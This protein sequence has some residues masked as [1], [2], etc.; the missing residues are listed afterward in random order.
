MAFVL[1]PILTFLRLGRLSRELEALSERVEQ[2]EARS[3]AA[4]AAE[5]TAGANAAA[6]AGFVS[7]VPDAPVASASA[8]APGEI[9]TDLAAAASGRE[10][11]PAAP[12]VPVAP[13]APAALEDFESRIGGRGLLYTGVLV[14][15]FGVSF[16]L[17][18]AFDNAWVNETGRVALGGLAGLALV[19]A[20]VRF[21]NHGLTVFG[22]ALAGTGLA[23]LY[24]AIYAA[25]SFYELIGP[26][27]AF[28]AMVL[29]TIGGAVLAHGQRAQALAFIAVGGG[30]LTPFLVGSGQN[31]QLT[32][33]S[34]LV[35]LV[36]GTLGLALR[37][38]WLA[39]N[40]VSYVFTV[41]TVFGW[42]WRHYS[43]DQWLR[44]LLFL[45]LFGVL[46]LIILRETA[47]A[48]GTT[49]RL[50]A[51]LLTTGP[52][53]YH[54][55]A[56]VITSSH[57]PAIHIYL[58]AFTAAGLWLTADPQRPWIR[59]LVL[60]GAYIPL[61]GTL[62]LPDGISWFVPNVVTIVAVAALHLMALVDR[63]VRQ[64]ENFETPDLV[65][66]QVTGLGLFALLYEA[67]QPVYP[68]FRGGLAALVALGALGLWRWMLPRERV[69]ALNAAALGFTLA[70]IG[71]AVEFDG[72][73]VVIG[74]AA[75]GAA[76]AWFGLRAPSLAFQIGGL[77]L[78]AL[79]AMQ[80][81]DGFF[82]T[83]VNFMML[84][85]ARALATA[86]VVVLGYCLAWLFNRS[87]APAAGRIRAALHVAV[88]V[89]TIMWIT[90]EIQSYWDV[91]AD[92]AQAF[93]Y[94][95]VMLSLAWGLYGALLIA[96][97]MHRGYAPV[98]YIGMTVLAITVLKVFFYDLWE[99]GGIYR[100]IGFLGFGILLVL[101]SYLYQKRKT[102]EPD[103][104]QGVD[105]TEP[106][107]GLR[108]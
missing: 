73:P 29:V 99:L 65:A 101:V 61:F 52:L 34:Y 49:A 74:W 25:L 94:E 98:R 18:Y 103:P 79:A 8:S 66:L 13:E 97:G 89:L 28:A 77:I 9:W 38:Q 42:A 24:L 63:I 83:P 96:L 82:E 62:T 19:A 87:A 15:L 30:F 108:P 5:S 3:A 6:A 85:N 84:V 32:L 48:S 10:G 106:I 102:V 40:A 81:V 2:L 14:L 33:F 21:A 90:A 22:Q 7:L 46:F 35:L 105:A 95:Q 54:M 88:S 64:E 59:L 86:F 43:D 57:P 4:A 44:T 93:L 26:T 16:F 56:I 76:A 71:I 92:R 107:K 27:A 60:L 80:L 67:L 51:A 91:R 23:V 68:N 100:V 31:A 36:A 50:V 39:L 78:W 104:A 20:G 12:A 69:A 55:A 1:M 53:L 37:H 41:L 75:E 17:K 45:T 72:P 70:A 47:R 11:G 58:I